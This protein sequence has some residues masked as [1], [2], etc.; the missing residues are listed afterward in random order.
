[1]NKMIKRIGI[2]LGIFVASVTICFVLYQ[3]TMEKSDIVYT[4]MEEAT[5]PVVYPDMFGMEMG[6]L[7]GHRQELGQS[8]VRE[9]L[10]ILPQ[11]RKLGIRIAEYGQSIQSVKYE[12]RS[13][14]LNRL[15]E[16]TT[17][18][19]LT[20]KSGNTDIV[21]PIQNLLSKDTQYL[22]DL[23]VET[24]DHGVIHYYARVMWTEND[25]IKD[26]LNLAEDFSR[27]TF[28]YEQA[29]DLVTYLE[30]DDK[31]DNSSL[32]RVTIR[33]SYAQLTW[34]GLDMQLEGTMNVTLKE[35]DGI[36]ANIQVDYL[37]SRVDSE[38][39]K[40]YYEVSDNFSMKWNT[41]RIYLME[42][43]R[44]T[45][46]IFLGNKSLFSG[47]RIMLGITN[48]SQ[49]SAEKSPNGRHLA[50]RTNRDLWSYDQEEELAVK[51][52]SF[53]SGTDDSLRSNRDQ[54][55]IKI[56]NVS[57]NG[58]IDFLVYGYMNR[59][60]HEGY[61]GVGIYRYE[62]ESNAIEENFFIPVEAT[63]EELSMDISQLTYLGGTE[64]LYLYL[65]QAVYG[66]DLKSNEY[67]V[68]ADGLIPGTYAISDD[69]KTLVWQDGF[70]V[71]KSTK[72]HMMNLETGQKAELT[73]PDGAVMR[74]LGFVNGD[75]I[76]G[77]AREEDLWVINGRVEDL[78]M[79][80]VEIIDNNQNLQTRYEEPGRYLSGIEVEESRIHM[81]CLRKNEI[82]GYVFEETD[83]IVC[84]VGGTEDPLR[85]IGWFASAERR[86]LYFVQADNEIKNSR[87]IQV[88]TPKKIT[89]DKSEDILLQSN[90]TVSLMD[91]Y[92]YGGGKL[93][94]KTEDFS[95]AVALAYEQM[96]YVTDTT[97]RI[98]WDRINRETS[99]T[100]KDP[101]NIAYRLTNHLDEFAE[102]KIY[103]DNTMILDA[104]GCSLNQVLYFID[105]GCPVVAYTGDKQYLLLY[106]FDQHNVSVYNP[107]TKETSKM[108]LGDAGFYFENLG[109]DF[110]CALFIQ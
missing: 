1:M 13:L 83:T 73:N 20:S 108:G 103:S 32:G 97:G 104:R 3:N 41:K 46:Q 55:D 5:L 107:S 98:L 109:N 81:N 61:V 94:D 59:G 22:M 62:V 84:N 42:F 4:T 76:Y 66:I 85:G 36:M 69:G 79:Y 86:K 88:S 72:L 16:R 89:Y 15:V 70:E 82:S 47:K 54:H 96:G 9:P 51:V 18:E 74:V 91:F 45:N 102:N 105:K 11:D 34:A 12:I 56:V 64:M 52:F 26:M 48:D 60:K 39:S 100:V 23:C 40:E 29:R 53:R 17:V 6:G 43:N 90:T 7:H 87:N 24:K 71:Y 50:F 31:E 44:E 25:Y 37:A 2:L 28:D 78:P 8:A 10:V 110:V 35:M 65:N 33:S 19:E 49:I 38:G 92:A 101:V 106:G 67:I 75:F 63:F 14:D 58:D 21:L 95:E 68:V 99:Q 30:T 27:K 77:L 80:A 93:L 57:D